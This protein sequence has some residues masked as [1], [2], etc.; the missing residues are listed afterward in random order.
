MLFN[1]IYIVWIINLIVSQVISTKIFIIMCDNT[2]GY[3]DYTIMKNEISKKK[4]VLNKY[5]LSCFGFFNK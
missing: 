2:C 4:K 1:N 3:V 5:I